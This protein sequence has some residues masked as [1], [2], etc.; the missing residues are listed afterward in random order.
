MNKFPNS[1]KDEE[2]QACSKKNHG[3]ILMQD[4]A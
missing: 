4:T 1:F 2:K 3:A